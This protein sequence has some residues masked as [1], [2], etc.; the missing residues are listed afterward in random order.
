MSA[1][2][3]R[4]QMI[5]RNVQQL[6]EYRNITQEEL[7]EKAGLSRVLIGQIERGETNARLGTLMS[8]A[9]ALNCYLDITYSPAETQK[10]AG[11][12]K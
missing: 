1:E 3:D 4:L 7:A 6:R 10:R 5:G 2:K 9:D 12:R 11:K 8:I